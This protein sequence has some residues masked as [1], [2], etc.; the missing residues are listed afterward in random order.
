MTRKIVHALVPVAVLAVLIIV[1]SNIPTLEGGRERDFF[2]T[3]DNF[4]F[5]AAQ[6]AVVAVAA[7]GMT[8]IMAA[9]GIDLS[10]GAVIA[11]SGVIAA[12]ALHN[13]HSTASAVLAAIAG[14]GV[15]G[16]VNG[17]LIGWCRVAPVLATLG[18]LG[19][20]RGVARWTAFAP[21]VP[22][23]PTWLDTLMV[24]VPGPQWMLAPAVWVALLTAL[25]VSA[26]VR[27]TVFGRYLFAIGSNETAARLCG[28]RVPLTRTMT[29]ALAGLLFGLAGVLQMA[30]LHRG[31]PTTATGME[32]DII[33]AAL[34]GG[35]S[36]RGGTGSVSG[37]FT[38]ALLLAVL[39][40]G[41]QQ[42]DC[43][44]WVEQSAAGAALIVAAAVASW[45]QRY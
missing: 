5:I 43:P 18:M 21:T 36:L 20:V 10:V 24:S 29:Y 11:L 13:G 23:A 19:V 8:L 2:L 35:A 45:R 12:S 27:N 15:V 22:T 37:A 34:I 44:V 17:A 14:A 31:D 1:F 16:F 3:W 32:V 40:N 33:A 25:A 26:V 30:R 38:G 9:G 4:R 42:A 6:T 39:R 7:L 41:I 28:I